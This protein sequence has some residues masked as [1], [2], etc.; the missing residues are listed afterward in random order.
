LKGHYAGRSPRCFSFAGANLQRKHGAGWREVQE[1]VI[2]QRL[3]SWG[4]NT[5]GNWSHDSVRLRRR[6]PYTDSIDS[7][8]ARWIEGSE[9]YWGKFPDPFDSGFRETLGRSMA[10]RKVRTAD[11]PWCIGYFSDNELGWGDELSLA[12]AAWRSPADQPAKRA[13]LDALRTRYGAIERLNAAWG[14][15]HAS[16]EAALAT[17]ELPSENRA[18]ADLEA[19]T[20]QLAEEYFR[21]ARETVRAGAPHQLYLGCR[22][23]GANARAAVAAAKYCDVVSYNL[24]Q[25]DISS[26]AFP[27]GPDVPLLVGEFH[28][29]AL[30]RGLFPPGLVPVAD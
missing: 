26:F 6:T 30:D 2:H 16:W 20:S 5:L 1:V 12:R 11:D 27:G 4:I 15:S 19:F 18:R 17:R 7:A 21:V 29:G 14:T 25:R 10:S 24:Y 23:A 9:G 13:F 22:F 28:F 3:R 8:G